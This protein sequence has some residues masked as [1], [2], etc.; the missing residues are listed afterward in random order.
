MAGNATASYFFGDGSGL[1]GLAG[2]SALAT[3]SY[4]F[5]YADLFGGSL[6]A[7]LSD[8]SIMM[9]GNFP[10][11][12]LMGM[13]TME[14]MTNAVGT[15]TIVPPGSTSPG[16]AQLSWIE[17]VDGPGRDKV[18]LAMGGINGTATASSHIG[19]KNGF[20]TD[21]FIVDNDGAVT[22]LGTITGGNLFTAGNSTASY[23]FGD[24]SNLTG[25]TG[26][27]NTRVLKSGDFMTGELDIANSSV[28]T[29]FAVHNNNVSGVGNAINVEQY[30][31]GAMIIGYNAGGGKTIFFNNS[32]TDQFVIDYDMN[33]YSTSSAYFDGNIT[34]GGYASATAYWSGAAQGISA[35]RTVCVTWTALNCTAT[36]TVVIT[37]G[38]ITTWP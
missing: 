13:I 24:G 16:L 15:L 38:L 6:P 27:D 19:M 14:N 9:L 26:T 29:A 1:T 8:I 22:A 3:G 31:T 25:V 4:N 17:N 37:D 23:F 34:A 2:G 21:T 12:P 35:S 20:G 30:A 18:I 28:W 5:Q 33:I 36:G 7:W 32:S 10:D 11:A